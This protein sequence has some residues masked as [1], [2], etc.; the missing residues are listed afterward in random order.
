M[1]R[2]VFR[3]CVWF[4]I[5]DFVFDLKY[6]DLVNLD[7]II[8]CIFSEVGVLVR[9]LKWLLFMFFNMVVVIL[10]DKVLYIYS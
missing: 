1:I 10:C 2:F 7:F 3:F 9:I 6:E 4:E 5:W 8:E